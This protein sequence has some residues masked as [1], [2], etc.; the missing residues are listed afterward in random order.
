LTRVLYASDLPA[1][2]VA[3][4][5][6][7]PGGFLSEGVRDIARA[8]VADVRNGGDDA[9]MKHAERLDGV[10]PEPIR[11]PEEEVEAAR[12]ELDPDVEESFRV[13]I[14]N[15]RAFHER[16]MDQPWKIERDGAEVSQGDHPD[17]VEV[18]EDG[19]R[20]F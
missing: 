20:I 5:L 2:E 9:L 14:E 8:I 10:R 1:K 18:L 3:G 16:E 4:Q 6:R 11:V 13:A 15:V 7:R 12:S 17:G 19:L